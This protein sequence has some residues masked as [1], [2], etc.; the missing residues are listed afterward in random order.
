MPFKYQYFDSSSK[1][2]RKPSISW[3][4]EHTYKKN[5][6]FFSRSNLEFFNQKLSDFRVVLKS[7]RLFIYA[8][9]TNALGSGNTYYTTREIFADGSMQSFGSD[10]PF[11]KEWQVLDWIEEECGVANNV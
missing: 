9:D 2:I 10:L 4:K 8:P 5:P 1:W 6:K 7:G 11:K 3:I